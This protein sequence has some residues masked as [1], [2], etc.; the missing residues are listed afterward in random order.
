MCVT[1]ANTDKL[2]IG[3]NKDYIIAVYIK[4]CGLE[5]FQY[6]CHVTDSKS[7]PTQRNKDTKVRGQSEITP[8]WKSI[9]SSANLYVGKQSSRWGIFVNLN[10]KYNR[11]QER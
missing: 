10:S 8:V 6:G 1:I 2:I 5:G 11:L 3:C 7:H 4:P 9:S